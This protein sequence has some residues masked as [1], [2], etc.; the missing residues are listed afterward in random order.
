MQIG[1]SQSVL[2]DFLFCFLEAE[3]SPAVYDVIL[4]SQPLIVMMSRSDLLFFFKHV[5]RN[6]CSYHNE[7]VLDTLGDILDPL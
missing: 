4:V 1:T 3:R 2:A 6:Y 7:P 5:I